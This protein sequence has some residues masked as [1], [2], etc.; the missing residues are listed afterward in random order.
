VNIA[1]A[2]LGGLILPAILVVLGLGLILR[3]AGSRAR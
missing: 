1:N 2:S 3:G